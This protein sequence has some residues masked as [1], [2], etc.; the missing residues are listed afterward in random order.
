M[1]PNPGG[2]SGKVSHKCRLQVIEAIMSDF[3][4]RWTELYAPTLM[5]QSK[6]HGKEQR[7]L[8]VNDV[9][10]VADSNA[11]RGR[12]FIARVC[13]IFPSQDGQ[14]RKVSLE[15]KSFRVGSRA[16]DYVVNKVI[17]I[18]RSVRKLALL[19]PCDD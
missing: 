7:N 13:E 8:K 12:Y 16:S 1:A 5:T 3:W 18:T 11:L 10:V 4:A 14:V 19:V 9:V 6:W 2:Y 15:Y 17:R